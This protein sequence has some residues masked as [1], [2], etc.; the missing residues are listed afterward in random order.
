MADKA[1]KRNSFVDLGLTIA[2]TI[3][4]IVIIRSLI[5]GISWED[6]FWIILAAAYCAVSYKYDSESPV[7]KKLTTAFL[8]L[9]GVSIVAM[10][11]IGRKP[12]PTMHAF[13][14]AS[15]DTIAEEEFI[16][17]DDPRIPEIIEDTV[18]TDTLTDTIFTE[19]I[20][21]IEEEEEEVPAEQTEPQE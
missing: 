14:G 10:L 7:V 16:V 12:Q 20:P 13:E 17:K 2:V 15:T 4:V 9:T 18:V 11:I 8:T 19:E 6:G 3:I 21:V 1:N 5:F